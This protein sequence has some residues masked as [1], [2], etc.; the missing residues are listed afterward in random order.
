MIGANSNIGT[1]RASLLTLIILASQNPNG[2]LP[3]IGGNNRAIALHPIFRERSKVALVL[4]VG[5]M[6]RLLY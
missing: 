2:G 4:G 3:A 6:C 1:K 5:V